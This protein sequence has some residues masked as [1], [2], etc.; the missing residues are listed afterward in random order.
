MKKVM[1]KN[2]WIKI[3]N[4]GEIDL[5]GLHLMGVSSK[6]G[7]EKIGFFG[8]G[9]KYAMALLL[10]EKIPF[11]I[12]SGKK[13]IKIETEPVMFR[14]QLFDQI[15]IDGEK[16]SLTTSMG[17]DWETW[18]AVREIYCN[19][20][21]E[22][23]ATISVEE[24]TKAEEGKTTIFIELTDKLSDFFKDIKSYILINEDGKIDEVNTQFGEISIYPA[25]ELSGNMFGSG[26]VTSQVTS[27]REFICYRKGIRIFPKN[28]LN[29]LYRYNFGKISINESR[30]YQY[31]HEVKERIAG[32]F[33]VTENRE[34]ILNYLNNW[35][36]NYEKDAYWQYV[37][38]P[39]SSAWKEVLN[40]KRV[41]PVSL[42]IDSGDFEGK[43]NSFI[44]PDELADKIAKEVEGCEVVGSKGDKKYIEIEP[45]PEEHQKISRAKS[46]LLSIG[47]NIVAPIK[48]AKTPMDD[49]MG[50]YDRESDTIFLTRK[51]LTTNAEI[52]NTLLEEH[53]HSKGLNDGQRS[54]VSFL[55]DE[56]IIEKEKHGNL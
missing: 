35:K 47:Y 44:V 14:N 45:T 10:R 8:S 2:Y 40:G 42:A 32:F 7:Q 9:N 19:A 36:N 52:K 28:E 22:G 12:Y 24:K 43:F 56:L 16:T 1:N 33:A 5:G 17:V 31:E 23:E 20:L 11:K 55:I 49:V 48:M 38:D 3:Q 51:Y 37:H 29:S 4:E 39:L 13:L 34:V 46:E 54:F 50:W 21:D 27:T 41:Y 30:V 53:F 15:L 26:N 25:K 18:F 6:R